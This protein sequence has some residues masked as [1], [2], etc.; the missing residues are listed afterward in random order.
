MGGWVG[1]VEEKTAVRMS[2]CGLWA[3]GWVSKEGKEGKKKRM[4]EWSRWVGGWVG[5]WERRLTLLAL[6]NWPCPS[7]YASIEGKTVMEGGWVGGWVG[8]KTYLAELALSLV[9]GLKG[10][11]DGEEPTSQR[12]LLVGCVSK[13]EGP[14]SNHHPIHLLHREGEDAVGAV[15]TRGVGG[16]VGG[17]VRLRHSNEVLGAWG[18]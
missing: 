6:L 4:D 15:D 9:I 3:G 16:W 13:F 11:E 5:G 2:Y 14:V 18:G 10:G 8:E 12:R 7:L 17:W 1:W